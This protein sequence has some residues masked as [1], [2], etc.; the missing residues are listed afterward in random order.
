MIPP[1]K[2]LERLESTHT[3]LHC[4]LPSSYWYLAS[5]TC[6]CMHQQQ[7]AASCSRI[8][9]FLSFS[10]LVSRGGFS[11]AATVLCPSLDLGKKAHLCW[12][13]ARPKKGAGELTSTSCWTAKRLG[14]LRFLAIM[15]ATVWNVGRSDGQRCA[16][17]YVCRLA[18]QPLQNRWGQ[19]TPSVSVAYNLVSHPVSLL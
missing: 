10:S 9:L 1:Y 14:S 3:M 11:S 6:T 2:T 18:H 16:R 15:A 13:C 4:R 17:A 8:T 7:P 5:T 19:K 12:L